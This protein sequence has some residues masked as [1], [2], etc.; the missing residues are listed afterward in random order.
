[1]TTVLA[2]MGRALTNIYLVVLE[3]LDV[4]VYLS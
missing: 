2:M 1:M 4:F 3:P